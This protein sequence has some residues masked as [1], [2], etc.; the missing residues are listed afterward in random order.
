MSLKKRN[1]ANE[2][3]RNEVVKAQCQQFMASAEE[4]TTGLN[5]DPELLQQQ[6]IPGT[7][8][9]WEGCTSKATFSNLAKF[10]AHLKNIHTEPLLCQIPRCSHK[11]PFRHPGDLERHVATIHHRDVR[12]YI[13][14][15]E[16]CNS[17]VKSFARKDKLLKHIRDTEH[18]GHM[19]CVFPHCVDYHPER[20]AGFKT[21]Q[22]IVAHF[23]KRHSAV[24][25]EHSPPYKWPRRCALGHCALSSRSERWSTSE[26]A[27]HLGTCRDISLN[28]WQILDIAKKEDDTY[29]LRP[30]YLQEYERIHQLK[31]FHWQECI[32]CYERRQ[33]N[34]LQTNASTLAGIRHSNFTSVTDSVVQPGTYETLD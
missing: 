2:G 29:I 9:L 15:F 7:R 20:F 19:F 18:S 3:G 6:W 22:E 25:L 24:A 21:R 11:K 13:C 32:I 5:N 27:E 30:E 12:P 10:K 34:S 26:L 17:E 28:P 33:T 8:C 4:L 31:G 16:N 1:S 14:P 23:K